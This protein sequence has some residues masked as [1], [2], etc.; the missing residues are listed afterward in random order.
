MP[1]DNFASIFAGCYLLGGMKEVNPT[2]YVLPLSWVGIQ[3]E[4]ETNLLKVNPQC[5]LLLGNI[6]KFNV[7]AELSTSLSGCLNKHSGDLSCFSCVVNSFLGCVD[8]IG[9]AFEAPTIATGFGAYLAQVR[10]TCIAFHVWLL[11]KPMNRSEAKGDLVMIR[12]L[13]L[14]KFKLLC[15]HAR[16]WSQGLGLGSPSASLQTKGWTTKCTTSKMTYSSFEAL[17]GHQLADK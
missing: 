12:T 1:T 11:A 3:C 6:K 17:I 2:I 10:N 13:L 8:K 14:F 7:A 5:F 15:Y 9:I 16:Y 4:Q